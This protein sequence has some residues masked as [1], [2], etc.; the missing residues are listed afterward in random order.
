MGVNFPALLRQRMVSKHRSAVMTGN[1]KLMEIVTSR[2]GRVCSVSTS[3]VLRAA[4]VGTRQA[5]AGLGFSG[6]SSPL[7]SA[8]SLTEP[9]CGDGA[10]LPCDVAC[11]LI[12]ARLACFRVGA[13]SYT[14]RRV[15]T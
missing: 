14:V 10:C 9:G 1:P 7:S 12:S 3:H 11:H 15:P 5:G 4:G 6:H 8:G 13:L 2:P